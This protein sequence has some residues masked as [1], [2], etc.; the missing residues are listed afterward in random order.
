MRSK[1]S[2]K[3]ASWV[4]SITPGDGFHNWNR[5]STIEANIALYKLLLLILADNAVAQ[6]KAHHFPEPKLRAAF[7]VGERHEF[8]QFEA[9]NPTT[10]SYIVGPVTLQLVR[11]LEKAPRDQI[12][13][14]DFSIAMRGA[15]DSD[16]ATCDPCD[17]IKRS[18]SR[19]LQRQDEYPSCR[20]RANLV[21]V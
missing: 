13:L 16:H 9:L 14:G 7:H 6:S 2:L 3:R 19:H 5:T 15:D 12:L 11:F 8:H 1:K 4:D 20:R 18:D 17:F 10:F 21:A